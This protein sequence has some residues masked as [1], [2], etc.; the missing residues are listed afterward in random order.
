M[1]TPDV[2][3]R[4]PR[5][6]ALGL[7]LLLLLPCL[8]PRL[9]H[10]VPH[11]ELVDFDVY[12][13]AAVL[14]RSGQAADL[15]RGAE[16]GVDP[17]KLFA[18]PGIPIGEVAHSLGL[19]GVGL[20]VYPPL[21]ADLMVPLT[22]LPLQTAGKVWL[23][24]NL[25]FLALTAL[26]MAALLRIRL[27]SWHTALLL[28]ATLGFT[29]ALQAF[30]L[31]QITIVL[32]LLW[33][34]GLLLYQRDCP[35]AAGVLFAIATVLKLTPALV[36]VPLL[37]WRS[38]RAV[39][40]FLGTV[41]VCATVCAAINTPH[42]VLTFVTRVMP[43]MS[44]AIPDVT[45]Y[46]L[47]A[48]TQ[49]LVAVVHN[50][51]VPPHPVALAAGVARMGRLASALAL[52]ALAAV[53]LQTRR[54]AQ[55]QDQVLVLGILTLMAPLLSPVS[56]FHAYAISLAAFA[57]LWHEALIRFVSTRYLLWLTVVTVCLG[58]PIYENLLPRLTL[59]STPPLVA[60]TIQLGQL[61]LAASL[62]LY[63]VHRTGVHDP[64][65]LPTLQD[66]TAQPTTGVFA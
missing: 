20:Y 38:W 39:W 9:R 27:L 49:R 37:V 44:G 28:L 18:G 11:I 1:S 32:L 65:S 40:G 56:W 48:A 19:P 21:L 14:V 42:T 26:L 16:T 58:T 41:L 5:K 34:T 31:G 8:G 35:L 64:E 61:L 55:K 50:G 63:R 2:K 12:Y 47:S 6:L 13:A 4:R 51:F 59:G 54:A 43:A 66:A 22:A 15:Y 23:G 25:A 3:R 7:L 52:A 24:V 60:A 33:T 36:L 29:P 10:P 45:N 57:L 62:V 46:S 17:Q 30:T 53:L